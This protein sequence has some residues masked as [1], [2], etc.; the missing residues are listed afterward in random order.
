MSNGAHLTITL[1]VRATPRDKRALMR[2]AKHYGRT[3]SDVL[4]RLIAEADIRLRTAA[5]TPKENDHGS[6]EDKQE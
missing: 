3:P 1:Q 5:I 2:L 6:E 4:R